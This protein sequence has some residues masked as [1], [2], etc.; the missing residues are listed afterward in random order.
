M[1]GIEARLE[2]TEAK[3]ARTVERINALAEER[4]QSIQEAL[5]LE[6]EV[7]LLK[8]LKDEEDGQNTH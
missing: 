5:R 1:T 3:L 7:R 4:Q 2:D 8:R 6:G